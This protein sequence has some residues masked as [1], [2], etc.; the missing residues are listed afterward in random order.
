MKY[1]SLVSLALFF[2]MQSHAMEEKNKETLESGTSQP[3]YDI[4]TDL[5]SLLGVKEPP[6][7][8]LESLNIKPNAKEPEN[9]SAGTAQSNQNT[10]NDK[11]QNILANLKKT[12]SE[13]L[14][15]SKIVNDEKDE[16]QS[17]QQSYKIPDIATLAKS[18]KQLTD[19]AESLKSAMREN[20]ANLQIPEKQEASDADSSDVD[21]SDGENAAIKEFERALNAADSMEKSI[22]KADTIIAKW[23]SQ[24]NTLGILSNLDE[25][26]KKLRKKS[27][28]LE[29]FSR[30]FQIENCT[31]TEFGAL[32]RLNKTLTAVK[33]SL[34]LDRIAVMPNELDH[35]VCRFLNTIETLDLP[36]DK[37]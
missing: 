19:V 23:R 26:T 34:V 11:K 37:K 9:F 18:A 4:V 33:G 35:P 32:K 25:V 2:S 8:L 17:H 31:L 3:P 27:N 10:A 6:K 21:D 5:Q 15:A 16:K 7:G 24:P 12:A 13:L 28:R 20:N 22:A 30:M 36:I 14:A 29:I 1:S